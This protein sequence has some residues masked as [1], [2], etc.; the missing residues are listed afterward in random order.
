[1]DCEIKIIKLNNGRDLPLPKYK[2][3]GSS[4]IELSGRDGF[5]LL[6]LGKPCLDCTI[7]PPARLKNSNL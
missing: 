1:M 5:N 7:Q 2:T 3:S 6:S 4:G